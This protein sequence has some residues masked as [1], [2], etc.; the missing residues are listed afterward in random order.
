VKAIRPPF[1]EKV[2]SSSHRDE[3]EAKI[4]EGLIRLRPLSLSSEAQN[5][6]FSAIVKR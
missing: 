1:G 5:M 2:G 6:L 3:D 4:L